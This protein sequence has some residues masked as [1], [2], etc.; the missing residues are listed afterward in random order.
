M[1]NKRATIVMAV[2]FLAVMIGWNPL[3]VLIFGPVKPKPPQ[4]T[5]E[6]VTAVMGGMAS[7]VKEVASLKRKGEI[8]QPEEAPKEEAKKDAEA[9][10]PKDHPKLDVAQQLPELGELI[11]IGH[12]DKPYNLQ[13][14]FNSLG[15]SVQQVILSQFKEANREGLEAKNR[16][17]TPRLLHLVPGIKI[18]RA[19]TVRGQN[20]IDLNLPEL[21]EGAYE[22]LIA[23]EIMNEPSFLLFHYDRPGDERPLLTLGNKKWNYLKD[24]SVIDCDADEQKVVFQT[25]LGEPHNLSIT[26]TFTLKRNEYHIGLKIDF[27]RLPGKSS[28]YQFRYQLTGAH[29]LPIEGEWYTSTYRNAMM[30]SSDDRGNTT[31]EFSDAA[32]IRRTEGSDRW[33]HRA[34]EHIDYAAVATQY[35]ASAIA[36][37]DEQANR[38]FIEFVRATPAD[39]H[40]PVKRFVKGQ[41]PEYFDFL[42][43]ITV[44]AI[45]EAFNPDENVTHKYLLYH[46]PVKVRL[47]R[48]LP[49]TNRR[50]RRPGRSLPRQAA[51]QYADRRP[52]A[53][54]ARTVRECHLIGPIWLLQRPI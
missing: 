12:G 54:R 50:R 20:A 31:R 21:H 18:K 32:S 37:D 47:L 41:P 4:P 29:G 43:D 28:P 23:D 11:R 13:V 17:G 39:A 10:N 42:D 45:S 40:P 53:E 38:N 44:R 1:S 46:G 51:P 24:Q 36:V 26:K 15:G 27:K 7:G 16:D 22:R 34:K 48:Q 3:M 8:E 9:P 19:P 6:E 35:F 30:G 25:E 5:Q 49:K 2:L 33:I 52:P 14:M